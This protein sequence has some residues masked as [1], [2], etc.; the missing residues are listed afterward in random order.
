[1][2]PETTVTVNEDG[3]Y[4]IRTTVFGELLTESTLTAIQAEALRD[5]FIVKAAQ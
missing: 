4:T 3:V 1:M 2:I 5:Y